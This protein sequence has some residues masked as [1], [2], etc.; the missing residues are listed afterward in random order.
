M[1]LASS[2]PAEMQSFVEASFAVILAD[3]LSEMTHVK[4]FPVPGGILECYGDLST[5]HR[6]HKPRLAHDC[7]FASGHHGPTV[8]TFERERCCLVSVLSVV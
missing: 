5:L 7:L 2:T 6:S 8:D 1:E 3:P 4:L